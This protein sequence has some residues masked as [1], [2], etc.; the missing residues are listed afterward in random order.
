M[1]YEILPTVS[2]RKLTA[3]VRDR[4][5]ILSAVELEQGIILNGSSYLT[6]A[7]TLRSPFFEAHEENTDGRPLRW[8]E[9]LEF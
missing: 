1:G 7:K 5:I 9:I 8:L 3:P 4:C 6:K 2:Q